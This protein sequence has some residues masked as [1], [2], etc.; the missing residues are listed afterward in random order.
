MACGTCVRVCPAKAKRVRDDLNNVKRL[1][2]EP[3]RVFV[4]IAPSYVSEFPELPI[5]NMV[6]A[7]RQLGFAG[8]SETALGA[9]IVSAQVIKEL[10]EGD[11]RLLL[12]SACPAAV[13]YIQKYLPEFS[14]SIAAVFSPLLAHCSMLRQHYGPDIAVVFIGPCGAKKN[15]G[16]RHPELLDSV[17]T[18]TDLQAWFAES[19]INPAALIPRTEDCFVHESAQEGALY[20]IEGGMIDTLRIQGGGDQI[21]FSTVGGLHGI[22]HVLGGLQPENV[23]LRIFLE[24]LACRGGCING[25]CATPG[26]SGL[27]QWQEVISR[28]DVPTNPVNRQ[29]LANI[30]ENICDL[31]LLGKTYDEQEIRQA[32]RRFGKENLDDELNCGGCGYE[33]C[34]DFAKAILSGHAESSMCLSF[35]REKAQKKANALMHCIPSAIVLVD[36]DL[37]VLDCNRNFAKLFDLSLLEAYDV[38]QGLTGASLQRI[39]SFGDLFEEVLKSDCALHREAL[40][41]DDRIFDLTIFPIE[42]GQVVGSV[43]SD[44]TDSELPREMIAQRGQEVIRK[45]LKTVQEVACLLGENMAETEI[46][47]RSLVEGFAPASKASRL[48]GPK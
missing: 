23:S 10:N 9:Q 43:I 28:A 14:H 13:T 30:D 39:L 11:K 33:T 15:E 12:S 2:Q 31:P 20:P 16:D 27:K 36:Q 48:S 6:A 46:L 42:P 35:L 1:L 32:L 26:Q 3:K 5:A 24:L 38:C 41:V 18:F 19:R 37:K 34:G 22:K 47:L 21:H 17:I 45:N 40:H 25:P 7:L 8:V 4:S 44:V 29:P